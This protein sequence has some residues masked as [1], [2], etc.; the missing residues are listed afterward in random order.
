[1]KELNENELR[2]LDGGLIGIGG[3][4]GGVFGG[5]LLY[6]LV[7][8]GITKCANDFQEGFNSVYKH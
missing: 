5:G 1:M 8:E 6:E 2:D 7:T 4:L 3:W